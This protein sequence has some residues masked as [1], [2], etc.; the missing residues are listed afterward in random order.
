[1]KSVK[2]L[3]LYLLYLHLTNQASA[4]GIPLTTDDLD[5]ITA[6]NSNDVQLDVLSNDDSGILNDDFKEVIAVC[7]SSSS[8]MDCTG[9]SYTDGVGTVTVNGTGSD[10]NVLFLANHN[11]SHNFQFKYIMHNSASNPGSGMAAVNLAYVEVNTLTDSSNDGCD[12]SD[13]SLREAISFADNDA[14]PS[15]INFKRDMIGTIELTSGLVITSNDLSIIG[16][17]AAKINLSGNDLFRVLSI[18]IGTERFLLSGLTLSQGQ[19]PGFENGGGILIENALETRLEYIRVINSYADNNGGGVYVFNSGL[20]LIN[21]EI[22]NNIAGNHGGGLGIEAGLGSD[23]SIENSTISSNQ[24]AEISGG[25]YVSSTFGQNTDLK[26]VTVAYNH[27]DN[28]IDSLI[29]GTGNIIIES[30][31]FELGLAIPNSNNVT[32][33]SIFTNL[34]DGNVFGDNN[35]T[36]KDLVLNPS[37]VEINN[38]GLFG[39]KIDPSSLAYNHVDDTVGNANC[40]SQITTDQFGTA[41]PLD[42]FCDAGAYEYIFIEEI[43]ASGFE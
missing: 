18:P 29:E 22:S 39:H 4:G 42:G 6:I 20:T 2:T 13:C 25:L 1:M 19:S 12:A 31:I 35:L 15:I 26:F 41:R 3:L 40:G 5:L 10:N 38:S 23:V 28:N 37:L 33:N 24:A 7:E 32:N 16:P 36:K 9:N 43:F 8:D 30:S 14:E 34:A 11:Q 21:S 17:G 27:T